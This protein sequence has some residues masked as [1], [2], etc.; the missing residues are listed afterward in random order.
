MPK[1][2]GDPHDHVEVSDH[3]VSGVQHDVDRGLRQEEAA[4]AR[5]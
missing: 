3:E 1:M 4:D 2:R 5:R